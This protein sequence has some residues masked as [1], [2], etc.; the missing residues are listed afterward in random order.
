MTF[1]Y[2]NKEYELMEM[3][4]P[5]SWAKSDCL[6]IMEIEY[7]RYDG[8]TRVLIKKSDYENDYSP[9]TFMRYR[10]VNYF[11]GV[12]DDDTNIENAKYFIDHEYDKNFS[13]LKYLLME[14]KKAITEFEHD[15]ENNCDTKGSLDRL[16]YAQS[17]IYDYVKKNIKGE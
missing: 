5:N 10:F 16:E 2:N 12:E 4:E 9:S 11:Y 17:D 13:E 3:V 15:F 1:E 14:L 7:V 6:I 8:D